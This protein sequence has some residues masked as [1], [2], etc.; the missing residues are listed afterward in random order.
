MK[1]N[2]TFKHIDPSES[3]VSYTEDQ[4]QSIGRF[5]LKDGQGQVLY[6]KFKGSFTVEVTVNTPEKYFKAS[7]SGNDAYAAVDAVVEKLERQF[8]KNRKLHKSHKKFELSNE[9]Y[10]HQLDDEF[11]W[12]YRHYKKAA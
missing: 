9:G 8:L 11:N 7:H 3:L 1:N 2:Y 4:L 10:L 12:S 6:S 5:L